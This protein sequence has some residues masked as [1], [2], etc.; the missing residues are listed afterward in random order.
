ML[1]FIRLRSWMVSA[2]RMISKHL[3][4]LFIWE[5]TG[6]PAFGSSFQNIS[7]YCLS[8]FHCFFH[9]FIEISKH[10]MLLFI[11]AIDYSISWNYKISKHLMLLFITVRCGN[12]TG[13]PEFQNISCY[14]LSAVNRD[15]FHPQSHFKTSHVIVYPVLARK[16][17]HNCAFQNISCYCLSALKMA[18]KTIEEHFKTS[19]VIVYLR[20]PC[21]YLE[22]NWYFKTSHVIVYPLGGFKLKE[23]LIF[24]NI[25]CYCLSCRFQDQLYT[26]TISKHLMLLFIGRAGKSENYIYHISKHLMLL[27]I[28][29]RPL[30]ERREL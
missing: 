26:Q 28:S 1:L 19:H 9:S 20:A 2:I 23:P 18:D 5:G 15:L 6:N 24:Q 14:C 4:L 10:L 7:C 17:I 8:F 27:F 3:M 25:S 22:C 16:S 13:R 12:G 29:D 11:C 21:F 30:F